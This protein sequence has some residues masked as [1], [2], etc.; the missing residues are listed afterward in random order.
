MIIGHECKRRTIWGELEG[1]EKAKR[2]G[3]RGEGSCTLH[4]YIA[5]ICIYNTIYIYED[6][7]M[8]ST[9]H[10]FKKRGKKSGA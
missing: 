5:H 1:G 8:K 6:S 7:I 9:N 2:E 4:I 3:T 10:C